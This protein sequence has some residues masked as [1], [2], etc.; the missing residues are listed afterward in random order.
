MEKGTIV[1]VIA[2]E[3]SYRGFEGVVVGEAF[4]SR[5]DGKKCLIVEVE[6]VGRKYLE[7][8]EVEAVNEKQEVVTKKVVKSKIKAVK[9]IVA[10]N[11]IPYTNKEGK[12]LTYLYAIGE[13]A[14]EET[15]EELEKIAGLVATLERYDYIEGRL[16]QITVRHDGSRRS[17]TILDIYILKEDKEEAKEEEPIVEE[18][19][20]E[21][22]LNM[23]TKVIS[24]EG[25]VMGSPYYVTV[26]GREVKVDGGFKFVGKMKTS[27]RE[28]EAFLSEEDYFEGKE[29]KEGTKAPSK[30]APSKN[31]DILTKVSE[32]LGL[33]EAEVNLNTTLGKRLKA[34]QDLQL[35]KG[36]LVRIKF[37]D[38][39]DVKV[40]VERVGYMSRQT[41]N[42]KMIER[43]Y[44]EDQTSNAWDLYKAVSIQVL[45]RNPR[46]KRVLTEN[47][48]QF[49]GAVA[50]YLAQDKAREGYFQKKQEDKVKAEAIRKELAK[51]VEEAYY[52]KLKTNKEKVQQFAEKE[53]YVVGCWNSLLDDFTEANIKHIINRIDL[54]SATDIIVRNN[55]KDYVVSVDFVDN[56][57]D[58][59]LW[60]KEE[61]VRLFGLGKFLDY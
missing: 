5:T 60:T 20:E 57:I 37:L 26:L 56:E 43:F 59:T 11:R 55:M 7:V 17:D 47:M 39:E 18:E 52:K 23:D 24:K 40:R 42:N 19:V 32:A 50:Y 51:G 49:N 35:K 14:I 21:Y 13:E 36:D 15:L 27:N 46:S 12:E 6:K 45:S 54:G 41:V 22:L 25:D 16:G 29:F 33:E 9:D 28:V 8:E 2:E 3:V 53:G 30:K 58:F 4:T 48:K 31:K 44:I 1:R 38:G 10:V 61:Y 34:V